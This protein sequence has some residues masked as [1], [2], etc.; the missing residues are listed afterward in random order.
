MN[1]NEV[2]SQISTESLGSIGSEAAQHLEGC[3]D[4]R[5]FRVAQQRLMCE[6]QTVK[7]AAPKF[8]TAVDDA[9]LRAY[10]QRF[11]ARGASG[12]APKRVQAFRLVAWGSVAAAI[13]V[14]AI[15]MVYRHSGATHG[16][17]AE[18]PRV[19][20]VPSAPTQV[21]S[22]RTAT[23]K[24][25][26]K[27]HLPPVGRGKSSVETPAV[28]ASES[29]AAGF[30]NLMYCDALS[31]SGPMDLIRIQ[32]P[33]SAFHRGSQLAPRNGFVQADVVVGSDGVARAI[34]IIK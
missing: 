21:S 4:C 18:S 22:V 31:C 3:E 11:E 7:S 14:V 2:R 29:P 12:K 15:L 1:C 34:R 8:S 30:Q 26:K 20:T 23:P 28:V 27:V 33:E 16:Q 10:R 13:L 17:I 6:L 32:V 19:I 9:V 25:A 5:D 24:P